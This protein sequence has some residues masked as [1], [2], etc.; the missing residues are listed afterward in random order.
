MST[1]RDEQVQMVADCVARESKL[2]D[3]ERSFIDSLERERWRRAARSPRS[4]RTAWT[5]YGRR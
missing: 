5:R 3:W 2:S 4:R 1:S